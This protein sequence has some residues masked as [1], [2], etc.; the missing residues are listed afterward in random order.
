MGSGYNQHLDLAGPMKFIICWIFFTA[1]LF[2]VSG[3]IPA[4]G[5]E[6]H[7][8]KCNFIVVMLVESC[9]ILPLDW[10]NF[11]VFRT[12]QF[13]WLL[14]QLYC[15]WEWMIFILFSLFVIFP[16]FL[17]QKH[18]NIVY[19]IIHWIRFSGIYLLVHWYLNKFNS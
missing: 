14:K 11:H 7:M 6:G 4:Y 1:L 17:L 12:S 18:I 5:H 13:S 8:F 3:E 9:S 15:L 2:R 19:L 16:N 10:E